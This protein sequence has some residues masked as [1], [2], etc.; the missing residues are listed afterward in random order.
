MVC[1]YP[2]GKFHINYQGYGTLVLCVWF[3][4]SIMQYLKISLVVVF[5][6]SVLV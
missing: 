4:I 6:F 1:L 5:H 3:D 2:S